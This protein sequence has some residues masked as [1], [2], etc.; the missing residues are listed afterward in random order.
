ML[1][2]HHIKNIFIE[3]PNSLS[4]R[5]LV[6]TIAEKYPE[7]G[8]PNEEE[9]Y[10]IIKTD[11]DFNIT[12]DYDIS[13]SE[14]S[15]YFDQKAILIDVFLDKLYNVFNQLAPDERIKHFAS[16]LLYNSILTLNKEQFNELFNPSKNN[17]SNQ[18]LN[19]YIIS[20]Q[21]ISKLGFLQDCFNGINQF[22]GNNDYKNNISFEKMYINAFEICQEFAPHKFQLFNIGNRFNKFI[23]RKLSD[24][25]TGHFSSEIVNEIISSF[26]PRKKDLQIYDPNL[27]TGSIFIDI[28]EQ[29]NNYEFKIVGYTSSKLS[30]DLC[31]INLIFNSLFNFE[32]YVGDPIIENVFEDS[33]FDCSISIPPFGKRYTNENIENSNEYYSKLKRENSLVY[34][35]HLIR[36]TKFGGK[37]IQVLN[38]NALISSN[39]IDYRKNL[40]E[41]NLIDRII[42]LPHNIF[43]PDQSIPTSIIIINKENNRPEKTIAFF[44]GRSSLNVTISNRRPVFDYQ[45]VNMFIDNITLTFQPL[46]SEEFTS[47]VPISF[48]TNKIISGNN[49]DLS[50]IRY[51]NP[52]ISKIAEAKGKGENFITLS[53]VVT[54]TSSSNIKNYPIE[55]PIIGPKELNSNI[56]MIEQI[57][58][59]FID[60]ESGGSRLYKKIKESSVLISRAGKEI[61]ASFLNLLENQ[62][63][64]LT[65]FILPYKIKE[66]RILQEYLIAQLNTELVKEQLNTR[67]NSTSHVGFSNEAFLSIEIPLPSIP[68]QIEWLAKNKHKSEDKTELASFIK[69]IPLIESSHDLKKEIERFTQSQFNTSET[70][71]FK[72]LFEYDKF[73]FSK[74][75]IENFIRVKKMKNNTQTIILLENDEAGIFGAIEINDENPIDYK[76]AQTINEYASFLTKIYD[77]LT[78]SSINKQLDSFAHTSRNFFFK[79]QGEL[80]ALLNSPNKEFQ[81]V[82]DSVYVETDATINYFTE[83]GTKTKDDYLLRNQ[84]KSIQEQTAAQAKF[85]NQIHELYSEIKNVQITKFNIKNIF[86]EIKQIENRGINIDAIPNLKAIGKPTLIKHAL[87]DIIGNAIKYSSDNACSIEI[88]ENNNSIIISVSNNIESIMD[89]SKYN[90]LGETWIKSTSKTEDKISS[91]IYYA[92]QMIRDSYGEANLIDFNNYKKNKVF[93]ILI[94]LKKA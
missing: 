44:D 4:I 75:E 55:L 47:F 70:V 57:P 38:D 91:G 62:S 39:F 73:P 25:R 48:A 61:K 66:D 20:L 51:C 40:V 30:L 36:K 49:Y 78:K 81:Q 14:N 16:L 23:C 34:L 45:Q 84:L 41:S 88:I 7:F 79:L 67:R 3:N 83:K 24:S 10:N 37:V 59:I 63:V 71:E 90:L 28:A 72:K 56:L 26:T 69:S 1:T 5:K 33:R 94:Q 85:Y 86:D 93:K 74:E 82:M 21:S 27:F 68:D 50:P 19:N 17:S 80:I 43:Y 8:K 9:I 76:K 77:F 12:D 64:L 2:A 15:E 31:K 60:A 52:I 6:K 11:P 13:L 53:E 89:E 65:N 42:S 54:A 46:N 35:E 87:L 18:S 22:F 32:I 29:T 92:F 58:T